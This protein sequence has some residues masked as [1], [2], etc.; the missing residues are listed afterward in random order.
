MSGLILRGDTLKNFGLR[1]PVPYIERIQIEDATDEDIE[2]FVAP[3]DTLESEFDFADLYYATITATPGASPSKIT[4]ATSLM[5]NTSDDFLLDE[6]KD[7]IMNDYYINF[8]ILTDSEH[9][10]ALKKTKKNLKSTVNSLA[11]VRGPDVDWSANA[12]S[13]PLSDFE[14]SFVV[15]EDR[16]ANYNRIIK[17]SGISGLFV[18]PRVESVSEMYV[19]AAITMG[20]LSDFEGYSPIVYA[21]NF[22]DLAYDRIVRNGS[23]ATR[24]D[25]GFFDI[26][27]NFYSGDALMGLNGRYHS[28]DD[29][30][31]ADVIAGIQQVTNT[32]QQF[33]NR[34]IK[35]DST[36]TDIDF[37]LAKYEEDPKLLTQLQ[38]YAA[39][40][41]NAGAGS[42]VG[43][44]YENFKVAI[45]NANTALINQP[46]LSKKLIRNAKIQDN[47]ILSS[48]FD[49][50]SGIYRDAYIDQ[51]LFYPMALQTKV[52]KYEQVDPNTDS[53]NAEVPYTPEAMRSRMEEEISRRLQEIPTWSGDFIAR[54]MN[55]EMNT[56]F[57]NAAMFMLEKVKEFL[58]WI[59]GGNRPDS[60]NYCSGPPYAA[61][62]SIAGT[63]AI[64]NISVVTAARALLGTTRG[65][66][67]IVAEGE[68]I[69]MTNPTT[70]NKCT[71]EIGLI[72]SQADIGA[73]NPSYESFWPITEYSQLAPV[74]HTSYE[75]ADRLGLNA[76][77]RTKL[78][79]K[80]GEIPTVRIVPVHCQ[81]QWLS[82]AKASSFSAALN[83][84]DGD[85]RNLERNGVRGD[86]PGSEIWHQFNSL[87]TEIADVFNASF[88]PGSAATARMH[89]FMNKYGL[90]ATT[91][92]R[93]NIMSNWIAAVFHAVLVPIIGEHPDLNQESRKGKIWAAFED[94][95]VWERW[96]SNYD[97]VDP[98]TG[99][100]NEEN[101]ETMIRTWLGIGSD[102]GAIGK[103]IKDYIEDLWSSAYGSGALAGD[104]AIRWCPDNHD[105]DEWNSSTT[106]WARVPSFGG[107]YRDLYEDQDLDHA[108]DKLEGENVSYKGKVSCGKSNAQCVGTTWDDP[109]SYRINSAG[110][111]DGPG[112]GSF[113]IKAA[114]KRAAADVYR[115]EFKGPIKDALREI[116]PWLADYHGDSLGEG[117]H[118]KLANVNIWVQRYG[119]LFFDMEKYIL[120]QS[121]VSK[122]LDVARLEKFLTYGRDMVNDMINFEEL[123]FRI[124]PVTDA[125]QPLSAFDTP[126]IFE[127]TIQ[128]RP[129]V[130]LG[131]INIEYASALGNENY[132]PL[133]V[134]TLDVSSWRDFRVNRDGDLLVDGEAPTHTRLFS[135]IIPR[136]L[137]FPQEEN[138]PDNYRLMA[139]NYN[140]F[141]E[142]DLA[143]YYRD[144]IQS[145]I[146]IA[147]NSAKIIEYMHNK[148]RDEQE[149]LS[150]YVELARENCAFNKFDSEFNTF[151]KEAMMNR[152]DPPHTAPWITAPAMFVTLTELHSGPYGGDQFAV[153]DAARKIIDSINPETGWLEGLMTFN[154]NFLAL[155]REYE[156]ILHRVFVE[157][158][159]LETQ[160]RD[161]DVMF[162]KEKGNIIDYHVDSE[163]FDLLDDDAG[164]ESWRS[165]LDDDGTDPRDTTPDFPGLGTS[166]DVHPAVD[167]GDSAV[168]YGFVAERGPV[169]YNPM[170]VPDFTSYEGTTDWWPEY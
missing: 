65:S 25:D 149:R 118:R 49:G 76:A 125:D 17:L 47:R 161:I 127:T 22:S 94:P 162:N 3:V 11:W 95:E 147:D 68:K 109:D 115:S 85:G 105:R 99:E 103:Q 170:D 168:D 24:S 122:Y 60:C 20:P 80:T 42:R 111:A 84:Y 108:I 63:A 156:E 31:P 130:H 32:Y 123:T 165:G 58:D 14:D 146:R 5:F 86:D 61:I 167:F 148:L 1:L 119:W 73:E 143:I 74:D 114:L 116:I 150:G 30:G 54:T 16:D 134:K 91:L 155:I 138:I 34:N 101:M 117:R 35:I 151:F 10:A 64:D 169:M 96:N 107:N 56:T 124:E 39:M 144:E 78:Y 69:P 160:Y 66:G 163:E 27:D 93:E 81:D 7:E 152:Y 154:D 45:N 72:D 77:Q 142:D 12:L 137:D 110:Y 132:S 100:L 112:R 90:S 136:N 8:F 46:I 128:N 51:D 140:S 70:V 44:M 126:A 145:R 4:I 133:A 48:E 87:R 9:I 37:I 166:E 98:S 75:T 159:G 38:K 158:G 79:V 19:F 23:V 67:L 57:D 52:A 106:S 55:E 15:T 102:D 88:F 97:L 59:F 83:E 6:F 26:N 121:E 139:F 62:Y 141:V 120:Y 2:A 29:F 21:M 13:M 41:P 104:L 18:R 40:F 153:L 50:D 33:R 157:T 89:S 92:E 28:T 43:R 82:L 135:H 53:S 71:L 36:L 113:G 129:S 131:P 164:A